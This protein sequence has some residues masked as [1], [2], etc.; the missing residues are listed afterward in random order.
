M[1]N[2]SNGFPV[3]SKSEVVTSNGSGDRV[4]VGTL[5]TDQLPVNS[6]GE[7]LL[8]PPL[9]E[10]W[11]CV[12]KSGA[13]STV[14]GTTAETAAVTV[15][16]PA[17]LMK[18]NSVIR[19]K[20]LG[21]ISTAVD[22]VNK[23][24]TVRFGGTGGFGVSSQIFAAGDA[25]TGVISFECYIFNR[26]SLTSQ[27]SGLR[28]VFSGTGRTTSQGDLVTSTYDTA[29]DTYVYICLDPANV[30]DVM[31]IESYIVEVLQ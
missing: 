14:T 11:R 10:T 8:A 27:I 16:I 24:Y 22:A 5:T 17:G 29:G 4:I 7:F 12:S 21:R 6:S 18:V 15:N 28:N 3:N 31:V 2:F 26:N 25:Q 20:A 19:V 1:A 9:M 23:S 30:G 13:S